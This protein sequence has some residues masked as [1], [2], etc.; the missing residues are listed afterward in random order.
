M[1]Q[2]AFTL[3]VSFLVGSSFSHAQAIQVGDPRCEY[4]TD[5]MGVDTA[6]PRLSWVIESK[7]RGQRQTAYQVLVAASPEALEHDQGDLWDSGKVASDE[8]AQVA[9]AG[10]PLASRQ[11]CY[12][13]VQAWDR[14]GRLGGWSRPARWEMGL[15]QPADWS[16]QWIDGAAAGPVPILRKSFRA[17][18]GPVRRVASARLYATALGLY[19]LRINGQRVGDHVLAPD[20]T[21]YRKRVRYQVYDVASLLKQGDNAMAALLGNGWYCG[22]IGN[23]GFPVLRQGPG[24]AGATRS[25]LLRRQRRA[26]RERCELEDP[27]QPDPCF[28]LHARRVLRRDERGA[29]LGFARTGRCVLAGGN[30]P[31]R[32]RPGCWKARSCSP[33]AR[34]AS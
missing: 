34:R 2:A 14:D 29:R 26:D 17:G 1:R 27:R 19:E 23:G 16:A 28:R 32:S 12:W 24:P 31:R 30:R 20:W 13:K 18:P 4:L 9:Y 10:R 25:D 7:Q 3:L 33:C 8:T 6:Q 15:L 11:V 21:D 22:H 5:P